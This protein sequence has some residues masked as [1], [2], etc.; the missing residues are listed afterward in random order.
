MKVSGFLTTPHVSMEQKPRGRKDCGMRYKLRHVQNAANGASPFP[1]RLVHYI[2]HM[3]E[4]TSQ[5]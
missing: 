4:E 2:R 5:G 1:D 3:T